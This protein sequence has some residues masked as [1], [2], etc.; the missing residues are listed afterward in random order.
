MRGNYER[1]VAVG[2][3]AKSEEMPVL[4]E[5]VGSLIIRYS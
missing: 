5:L 3:V 2:T 1:V 4:M